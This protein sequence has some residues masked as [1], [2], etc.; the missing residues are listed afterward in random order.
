MRDEHAEEA[1]HFLHG[2]VSVV[3]ESAFLMNGEF[4][5][6]SFAGSD[7]FLADERYAVLLD[8]NFQTVPMHGGTF[9]KSVF[10]V[11]ADAVA[12]R[13]L[14]GGPGT[15]AVVTPGIYGFEGRDFLFEGRGFEMKGLCGAVHLER[16][17]GDVRSEHGNGR[18]GRGSR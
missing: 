12:L 4:I 11:D 3:E 2:A 13:D 15:R 17:I 14:N 5:G 1:D 16:A 18:S 7:G 6:I 10:D 9:R 8:R